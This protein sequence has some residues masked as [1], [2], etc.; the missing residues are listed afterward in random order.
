[1]SAVDLVLTYGFLQ[2][3][4]AAA[5]L[6]AVLAGVLG[7]P[8]VLRRLSMFGLGLAH[9]AFAGVAVGFAAGV[10]PL[11]AA[12]AVAVGSALV[13]QGLWGAGVLE[14]DTALAT[15]TTTGFAAGLL[16]VSLTGGFTTDLNA[17][18]FG[19]L[20]AVTGTDLALMAAAGVPLLVLVTLLYKELFYVTFD[21]DAARL[22]GLPV[23]ALDAA[24][25]ALTATTIVLASRVVG[26]LLVAALL[27]IPA[28]T[29]L[30]LA[31]SFKGVVVASVVA[32]LISVLVGVLAAVE[33]GLATGATVV[34]ASAV[35]FVLVLGLKAVGGRVP[36]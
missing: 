34:L 32:G 14:S 27:V 8:L 20:L 31:S 12:L 35:L 23:G 3:A 36:A 21:P 19:N 33:W 18:L 16:V 25:M 29:G 4:L 5:L 24:F 11:G 22:S 1:V 9:V 6:V 28:A 10:Y 15:V 7:V 2:R 17:Y 13:I 30:Q 26:L